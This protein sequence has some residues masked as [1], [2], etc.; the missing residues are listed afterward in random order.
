[1]IQ[2]AV[3]QY[4][5]NT[6]ENLNILLFVSD[7]VLAAL[8]SLIL[9][10]IYTRFGSSISNKKTFSS[11]FIPLTLTTFLVISIIKSSLALSLGLVG[12]LSI[13]RFRAA[14]K[15]PEELT[16]LFLCI[17]VGL[18]FGAEQRYMTLLA[19]SLM[20]I[21]LIFRGLVG[22]KPF[23]FSNLYLKFPATEDIDIKNL[24]NDLKKFTKIST[25]RRLDQKEKSVEILIG[26][27]FKN[28]DDLL[29]FKETVLKNYKDAEISFYEDKGIIN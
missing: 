16:Y 11:N 27:Q 3:L 9:K 18:G 23:T 22:K 2:E 15:E 19:F 1:M 8:L 5:F 28:A 6:A 21:I 4:Y 14:I 26:A 13:V 10:L 7:M 17:S 20:A 29:K 25:L 24:L 12:A